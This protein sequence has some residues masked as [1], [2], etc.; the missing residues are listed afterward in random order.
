MKMKLASRDLAVR[1]PLKILT[2]SK[3]AGGGLNVHVLIRDTVRFLRQ[4]QTLPEA[5]LHAQA[6]PRQ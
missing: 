4:P 5:N 6:L 1:I 3:A 2:E